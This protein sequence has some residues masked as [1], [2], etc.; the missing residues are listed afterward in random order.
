MSRSLQGLKQ[1]PRFIAVEEPIGVGKTS[2][3]KRLAGPSTMSFYSKMLKKTRFSIAS[4][5]IQDSMP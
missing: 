2:L 3:T 4:T 5:R 1:A